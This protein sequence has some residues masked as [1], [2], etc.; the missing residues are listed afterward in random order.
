MLEPASFLL[1]S[2]VL[3]GNEASRLD[4]LR[5]VAQIVCPALCISATRLERLNVPSHRDESVVC[6]ANLTRLLRR[7]AKGIED[8]PLGVDVEKRLRLVLPMEIHEQPT[9]LREN[10]RRPLREH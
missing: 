4:L 9:D 6:G 7:T 1:Q 8:L 10:T 3:A 5:D 2:L